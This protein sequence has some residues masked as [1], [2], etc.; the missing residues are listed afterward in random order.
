MYVNKMNISQYM[1][2]K[3]LYRPQL[4]WGF[5]ALMLSSILEQ[6]CNR[7]T[8]PKNGTRW[9]S[10]RENSSISLTITISSWFSSKIASFK[11]SVWKLNIIIYIYY[12]NIICFVNLKW[13]KRVNK[14]GHKTGRHKMVYIHNIKM[15][16][17]S[18][19]FVISKIKIKLHP[20]W[21]F[22]L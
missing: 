18:T 7:I 16:F 17:V 5:L 19:T 9:C 13:D 8:L 4:I 12:M 10:Q 1:F 3:Y 6:L 14:V 15:F 21:V 2:T 11:I 20:P 22:S